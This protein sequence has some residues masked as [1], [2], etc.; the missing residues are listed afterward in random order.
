M[1]WKLRRLTAFKVADP[2]DLLSPRDLDS[3]S[4]PLRTIPA[5][6]AWYRVA[7]LP[8]GRS[9]PPLFFGKEATGRFNAP[10]G[11]FGVCYFA[12]EVMGALA[13]TL[14]QIIG[15]ADFT[16]VMSASLYADTYLVSMRID[17]E[18]R[19]VPCYGSSL[20]RMGADA[21]LYAVERAHARRWSAA[22]HAHTRRPDGLL[23]PSRHDDL[24]RSLALYD[25]PG[26]VRR[27]RVLGRT[28]LLEERALLGAFCRRYDVG[29]DPL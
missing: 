22:L 29:I 26:V 8:S 4:I 15:S 17:A 12:E 11:S 3:R 13:E 16:R 10:D 9:W 1:C 2:G 23:Y 6:S 18:L 24:K 5:G 7:N 27:I 19:V 21:R 14:L 25:R 20:A 28:R